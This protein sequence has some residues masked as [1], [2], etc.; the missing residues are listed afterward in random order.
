M[1]WPNTTDG[2]VFRKLEAKDFDFDQV[3]DIDINID[4]DNWP[5]SEECINFILS[6]WPDAEIIE[7]NEED[8]EEGNNIGWVTFQ[9]RDQLT[10][11]MIIKI[12]KEVSDKMKD[13][14]GWCDSWG[15][16]CN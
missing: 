4:F 11:D 2:D 12:Q 16:F 9:I 3:V 14:G 8:I 6:N 10:Y 5:L 13:Y 15:L 1:T 7:P